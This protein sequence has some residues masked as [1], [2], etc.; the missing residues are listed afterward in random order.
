[1]SSEQVVIEDLSDAA[2][3]EY[4]LVLKDRIA[5]ERKQLGLLEMTLSQ[6]MTSTNA[7]ALPSGVHDIRLVRSGSPQYSLVD[8]RMDLAEHLPPDE[9]ADCFNPETT[10]VVP[11]SVNARKVR[12]LH[13]KY[14]G[15][16]AEL[17]DRSRT[18]NMKVQVKRKEIDASTKDSG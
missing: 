10:K 8:L 1:M 7:T 18:D 2:L 4:Y 13:T 15:R 3:A 6:R 5:R 12:S 16:V 17:I 14:G 9:L 11:E